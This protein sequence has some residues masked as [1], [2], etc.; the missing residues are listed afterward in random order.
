MAEPSE[1]LQS[2]LLKW[3]EEPAV[4]WVHLHPPGWLGLMVVTGRVV[5][6]TQSQRT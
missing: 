1:S 6:M 5:M 3:G 4:H 2:P